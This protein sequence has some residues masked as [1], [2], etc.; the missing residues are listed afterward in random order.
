MSDDW[1]VNIWVQLRDYSQYLVSPV[2]QIVSSHSQHTEQRKRLLL[3]SPPL[4]HP[5]SSMPEVRGELVQL[6]GNAVE[7]GQLSELSSAL[8]IYCLIKLISCSALKIWMSRHCLIK[9]ISCSA[10]WLWL[11]Q[12]HSW[13]NDQGSG[14]WGAEA[15][16]RNAYI[17]PRFP[18]VQKEGTSLPAI[19]LGLCEPTPTSLTAAGQGWGGP[20]RKPASSLGMACTLHFF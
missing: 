4:L 16:S 2:V 17:H 15:P 14:S 11:S 18:P 1:A 10:P 13:R 5:L 3:Q 9:L 20:S 8:V 19:A 6:H 12:Q 7:H